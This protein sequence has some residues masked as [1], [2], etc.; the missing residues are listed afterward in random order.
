[1]MFQKQQ[2][3]TGS[4]LAGPQGG[5]FSLEANARWSVT[6]QDAQALGVKLP[7]LAIKSPRAKQ[8]LPM[9]GD[10]VTVTGTASHASGIA[11][12]AW[13]VLKDGSLSESETATGTTNWNFEIPLEGEAGGLYTVFAKAV[14]QSGEQSNVVTSHFRVLQ[15]TELVVSVDGPGSVS[16]GFLGSTTREV[17]RL[18][19]LTASPQRGKRF[20]GWTGSQISTAR[21]ISFLMEEGMV[22]HAHFGN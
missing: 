11:E 14:G 1:M 13:Q 8:V 12:V 6:A 17:G 4:F 19:K 20:L 10:S 18:Y 3:I 16:R 22:L 7:R 5:G 2:L 21:T 15:N 9:G